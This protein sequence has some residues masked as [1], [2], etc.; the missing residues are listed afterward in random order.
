MCRAYLEGNP[1]S[2]G[3]NKYAPKILDAVLTCILLNKDVIDVADKY[4]VKIKTKTGI[5]IVKSLV[6]QDSGFSCESF[7]SASSIFSTESG[8]NDIIA[9]DAINKSF[10][11]STFASILRESFKIIETCTGTHGIHDSM[12]QQR[13]SSLSEIVKILLCYVNGGKT[14]YF[15]GGKK[16]KVI[17]P[18]PRFVKEGEREPKGGKS[19]YKYVVLTGEKDGRRATVGGVRRRAV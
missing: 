7:D 4:T 16:G 19:D 12:S 18:V 5:N 2:E 10:R 8:E 14:Q 9:S 17:V 13:V 6:D 3:S 11:R 15:T 1:G